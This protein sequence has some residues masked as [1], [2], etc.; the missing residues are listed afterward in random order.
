M[1]TPLRERP[2]APLGTLIFRAGLLPAEVI[3][4]ALEE[5]VRTG[6]RLG[7][8]LVERGLIK[9]EDL[10]RLLAGQKGLPYIGLGER[11]IDPE[12]ARLLGEEQAKLFCAL[13]IAFE[14]GS[15][16]VAVADPTNDVLTRNV[17]DAIGQPA[18][19]V[20]A[21]RTEL[22]EAIE[23]VYGEPVPAPA[24]EPI[25]SDESPG[26]ASQPEPAVE[27]VEEPVVT[28]T[29]P[30]LAEQPQP[31]APSAPEP[32]HETNGH[33][34][35][36]S[37]EVT[38]PPVEVEPPAI[39]VAPPPAEVAPPPAEVAPPPAEVAPPPA[40]V[41]PLPV[42]IEPPAPA[43]EAAEA[44]A[45]PVE[46]VA[47]PP[48]P[49]PA[50]PEPEPALTPAS[51]RVPAPE[52]DDPNPGSARVTI[53]LTTGERVAVAEFPTHDG[54]KEHARSLIRDLSD[55]GDEW[56]LVNG[57]FLKPETIVSVDVESL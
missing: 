11:A 23:R 8:I 25:A 37:L 13:P 20:V 15:P 26:E 3:E 44:P 42:E 47:P 18:S 19:F 28:E 40:E 53:R 48:A 34:P 52:P 12:A 45:A 7:E 21:S 39:E 56:P 24:P 49:T 50:A 14:E 16:V 36:V 43:A 31:E 27:Q 29:P 30:V 46:P 55:S 2:D 41:A 6:R 35:D 10:T 9:E 38:P 57:R 5:G 17:S 22:L 54:A 51:L 4:N 1:S 32:L 33:H